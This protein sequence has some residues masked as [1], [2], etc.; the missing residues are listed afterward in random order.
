MSIYVDGRVEIKESEI[1]IREAILP[2]ISDMRLYKAS[3]A[4]IEPVKLSVWQRLRLLGSNDLRTWWTFDH[5]RPFKSK[6]FVIRMKK[7][8][9]PFKAV[10]LTVEDFNAAE[11]A[12]KSQFGRMYKSA[13]RPP[14]RRKRTPK[15]Q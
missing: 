13:K 14:R 9:G 5:A 1:A 2:L 10:G 7:S 3:I 15:Q 12:F 8:I 4:S 11:K 6:G